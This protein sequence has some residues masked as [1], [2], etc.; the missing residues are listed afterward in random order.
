[1]SSFPADWRLARS[2]G[3]L[4]RRQGNAGFAER[5]LARARRLRVAEKKGAG[6][7]PP[8]K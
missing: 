6:P 2:L 1:V 8:R 4:Y 5:F 7:R 3:L